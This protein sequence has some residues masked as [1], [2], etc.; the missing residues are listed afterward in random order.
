MAEAEAAIAAGAEMT[1][2]PAAEKQVEAPRMAAVVS[3]VAMQCGC[4]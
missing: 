4:C 2:K 1:E 3:E